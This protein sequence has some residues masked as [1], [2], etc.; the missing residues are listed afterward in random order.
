[1]QSLRQRELTIGIVMAVAGVAYLL[2]THYVPDKPGVDAAT[3]PFI[4]GVLM[5]VLGA[6]QIGTG[7]KLGAGAQEGTPEPVDYGT[8]LKTIALVVAYMALLTPVGFLVMTVVYLFLQ[9]VV[10]TPAGRKPGYAAYAVIAVV[11]SVAVYALFRYAFDVVLPVGLVD[12][13]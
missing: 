10:L 1:M 7:L 2:A 12:L 11:T 4:L 3:V 13:G 6:V 9:F 8:T 5:C